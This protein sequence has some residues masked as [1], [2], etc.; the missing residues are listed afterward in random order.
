MGGIRKRNRHKNPKKNDRENFNPKGGYKDIVRENAAFEAFYR[1]HEGMCKAEE[2][3]K[4]MTAL[5]SDLPASF[6][7]TGFRSQAFAVRDL[8]EGTYFTALTNALKAAPEEGD[9]G[10]GEN[11]A[12]AISPPKSLP[13]YPDRLAWQLSITRN[14]I[15]REETL[16]K[17]HNFLI[18]ETESGEWWS[19]TKKK[20]RKS[21]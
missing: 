3:D 4:M 18:S 12:K 5:K 13:W 21:N 17:L 15:R 2:F 16:Y 20:W 11:A 1:S 14:D 6:R 9:V 19:K 8:I 7:V 10:G